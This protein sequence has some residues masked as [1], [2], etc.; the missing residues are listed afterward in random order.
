MV[1]IS[2]YHRVELAEET[3]RIFRIFGTYHDCHHH[4]ISTHQLVHVYVFYN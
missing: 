4:M 3:E 1:R 2:A